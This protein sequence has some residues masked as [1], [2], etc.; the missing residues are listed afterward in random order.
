MKG[1]INFLCDGDV[2]EVLLLDLTLLDNCELDS[3]AIS[4]SEGVEDLELELEEISYLYKV[5]I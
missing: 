4:V 3:R 2:R 5:Q 1:L